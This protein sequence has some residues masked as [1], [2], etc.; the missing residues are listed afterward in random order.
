MLKCMSESQSVAILKEIEAGIWAKDVCHKYR[1]GN[2][3]F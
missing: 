2:S 3:T 1:I